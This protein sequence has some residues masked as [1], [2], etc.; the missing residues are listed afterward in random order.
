[1]R[2]WI[3]F[4]GYPRGEPQMTGESGVSGSS[5]R[6]IHD[7]LPGESGRIIRLSGDPYLKR[8]L[9]ELGFTPGARVTVQKRAPFGDPVELNIRNYN[10]AVRLDIA[11]KILVSVQ[12][13]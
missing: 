13:Q 1:M 10:V 2:Q 6:S 11:E 12:D 4:Q 5:V 3:L 9:P 7:L 8:R